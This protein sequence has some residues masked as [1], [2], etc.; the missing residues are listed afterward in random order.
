[1]GSEHRDLDRQ[2]AE[3]DDELAAH[4]REDDAC[5]RLRDI[6]GIGPLIATALAAAVGNGAAF[7]RGR[8]FAAWLG[9]TPREHTTGGKRRLLGISKRGNTYLRTQLIHGARGVLA[10]LAKRKNGR[11]EWLT[12][13]RLRV[14][15]NTAVVA[16]ANKLA[17][18]AWAV[19][20][21]ARRFEPDFQP[22]GAR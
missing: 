1:M 17:R 19:L 8:D 3:I 9:L 14:H 6:P 16:L 7:T 15:P 5:R 20:S 13:L 2:I 21:G 18:I 10:S 11:G 12:R 4:S 22:E